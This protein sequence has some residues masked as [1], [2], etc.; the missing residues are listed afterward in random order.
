MTDGRAA[1][2]LALRAMSA[3]ALIF[4][5]GGT[6]LPQ[7]VAPNASGEKRTEAPTHLLPSPAIEGGKRAIKI[8]VDNIQVVAGPVIPGDYVDVVQTRSNGAA[9]GYSEVVLL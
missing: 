3:A 2:R 4:S 5:S 6:A 7:N 1:A 8:S 9:N